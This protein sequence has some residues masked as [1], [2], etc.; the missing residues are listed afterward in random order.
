MK[1]LVALAFLT[2]LLAGP[3]DARIDTPPDMS[4]PDLVKQYITM[5][6]KALKD[7]YTFQFAMASHDDRHLNECYEKIKSGKHQHGELMCLYALIHKQFILNH[8]FSSL[9]AHE[10]MCNDD[11]T[12]KERQYEIHF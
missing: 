6:C 2:T 4:D 9:K 8:A 10:L 5:P 1:W 12:T 7:S 11:D 3:A